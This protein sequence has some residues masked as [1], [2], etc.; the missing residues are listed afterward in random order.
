MRIILAILDYMFHNQIENLKED[1][2]Y[3]LTK[4]KY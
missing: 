1:M 3:I 4:T 2:R